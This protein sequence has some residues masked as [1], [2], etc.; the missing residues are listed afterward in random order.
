[1][2]RVGLLLLAINL[3]LAAYFYSWRLL[4]CAFFLLVVEYAAQEF[5]DIKKR[6]TR[7]EEKLSAS[8]SSTAL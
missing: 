4:V 2:K 3:G 6:L 7:I 1:M 8:A 5:G